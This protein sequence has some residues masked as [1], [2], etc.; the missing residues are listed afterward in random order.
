M[1]QLDAVTGREH[2]M[3]LRRALI[4]AGITVAGTAAVALYAVQPTEVQA[5]RIYENGMCATETPT[6]E[7]AAR[8]EAMSRPAAGLSDNPITI[9][10]M[11]H[12]I[13]KGAGIENGDVPDTMLQ[14]QIAVLNNAF[15]GGAGGANTNFRFELM[16]ITRTTNAAWYTAAYHSPE[17]YAMKEALRVGGVQTLNIY[18]TDSPWN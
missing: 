18:S 4:F 5:R 6:A 15:S 10:V 12:V 3:V 9:Q 11:Y 14:A 1:R 16:G 7:Q 8:V 13:N 17:E 2:K